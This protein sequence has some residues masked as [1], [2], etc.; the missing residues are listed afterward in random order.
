MWS[1][2]SI[3]ESNDVHWRSIILCNISK[4]LDICDSIFSSVVARNRIWRKHK[5]THPLKWYLRYRDLFFY[6]QALDNDLIEWVPNE[7]SKPKSLEY[8][9]TCYRVLALFTVAVHIMCKVCK[10]CWITYSLQRTNGNYPSFC[11]LGIEPLTQHSRR[12]QDHYNFDSVNQR[13][14]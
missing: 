4:S 13:V 2:I 7:H 1:K 8:F 5:L 10:T 11:L 9:C 6:E 12:Y 3:T 14:N